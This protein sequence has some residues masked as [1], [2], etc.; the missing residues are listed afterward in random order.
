MK[1]TALAIL[2]LLAV[3]CP[4]AAAGRLDI[5]YQPPRLSVEANGQTLTQIL[6]AIGAKV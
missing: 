1:R 4:V 3:A 6:D 5:D 2:A